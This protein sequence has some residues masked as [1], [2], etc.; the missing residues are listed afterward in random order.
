MASKK[1]IGA[2]I[3]LALMF[4][5]ASTPGVALGDYVCHIK[6][7]NQVK[8][9]NVSPKALERHLSHGD[10]EPYMLYLDADGDGFGD[11]AT[12]IPSCLSGPGLYVENGDDLD[13]GDY[14]IGDG[15]S[16]EEQEE[17]GETAE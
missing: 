1:K 11:P 10:Y 2:Q 8:L 7:N 17:E 9:L 3:T 5:A 12:L 16:D 15:I 13:D 14:E 6:R 4:G